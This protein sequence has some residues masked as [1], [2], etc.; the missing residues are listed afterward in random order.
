MVK[1]LPF[2]FIPHSTH[3]CQPLDVIIFSMMQKEYGSLVK[4]FTKKGLHINKTNFSLL[5]KA[6]RDKVLTP[7]NIVKSFETCG[8]YPFSFEASYANR[9]VRPTSD[10]SHEDER[11]WEDIS[12]MVANDSDANNATTQSPPTTP[13]PQP[14][15]LRLRPIQT[16]PSATPA[17]SPR[18]QHLHQQ[19]PHLRSI[20]ERIANLK[21]NATPRRARVIRKEALPLARVD[22]ARN[23][24][25]ATLLDL[26]EMQQE[27]IETLDARH[28]LDTQL[29]EHLKT[30]LANKNRGPDTGGGVLRTGLGGAM[31]SDALDALQA[32]YDAKEQEKEQKALEKEQKKEESTR[33]KAEMARVKEAR[34]AERATR[35][36]EKAARV[37][38]KAGR[39]GAGHG[40]GR[41]RGTGRG[42]GHGRGTN[43]TQGESQGQG[44]GRG[45]GRGRVAQSF[46]GA[47]DDDE[48]DSDRCTT[49]PTHSSGSNT[50]DEGSDS[51]NKSDN[52]NPASLQV[53]QDTSKPPSPAASVGSSPPPEGSEG[54]A[55]HP[56]GR[57]EAGLPK[58]YRS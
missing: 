58:R 37:A 28:I 21:G 23:E 56:R 52:S 20:Q 8:Y 34:A 3:L 26:T 1:I 24:R 45:R 44:R 33:K 7:T 54:T 51:E 36:A 27:V 49:S 30:Q 13:T 11:E 32:E 15:R 22:R 47:M 43:H 18:S 5:L 4:Q 46:P 25:V 17:S 31:D 55:V 6:V 9:Q 29:I 35:A 16:S 19:K 42:R 14:Q 38:E 57:R 41:G 50:D 48:D 10:P 2:C 40:R 39:R 53:H 12:D